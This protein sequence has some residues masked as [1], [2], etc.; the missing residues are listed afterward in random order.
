MPTSPFPALIA[1]DTAT[2]RTALVR[3]LKGRG[4]SCVEAGTAAAAKAV[5]ASSIVCALL[6]L[7]L[8]DG[9][10]VEVARSLLAARPELP[11]AFF[12][13]GAAQD[14]LTEARAIG[15]V[16]RKPDDLARAVAW[17]TGHASL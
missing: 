9:T 16:F 5:D 15:P 10:G 4:I 7:D 14:V 13:A 3:A 8:G 11:V 1:D 2:A 17:V 12:S 6:D